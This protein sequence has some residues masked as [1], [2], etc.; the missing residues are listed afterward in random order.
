MPLRKFSACFISRCLG[1]GSFSSKVDTN[2][3]LDPQNFKAPLV[4]NE[5]FSFN[6]KTIYFPCIYPT[7]FGRFNSEVAV[8]NR[9][10]Q[11]I[12][13]WSGFLHVQRSK[14]QGSLGALMH[15]KW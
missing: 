1:R 15:R 14:T 10:H 4:S 6:G 3:N 2:Q 13:G 5:G 7:S 9:K 12:A 11:Q 8:F